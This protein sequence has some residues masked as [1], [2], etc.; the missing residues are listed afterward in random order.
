MRLPKSTQPR[1]A[2]RGLARAR[3]TATGTARP[4]R[5]LRRT[6][7][8]RSRR[9]AP[10]LA[11]A[12]RP[13]V[14]GRPAVALGNA[15]DRSRRLHLLARSDRIAFLQKL[16]EGRA[17]ALRDRILQIPW[18]GR[19]TSRSDALP[20]RREEAGSATARRGLHRLDRVDHRREEDRLHD[21]GGGSL[22]LVPSRGWWTCPLPVPK[23][24]R[25]P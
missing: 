3:R 13:A 20:G 23:C 12:E 6:I 17:H 10:A 18:A 1:L 14:V 19:R 11:M 4:A 7:A 21:F 22:H 2:F 5:A 15:I 16:G 9:T 24:A 8:L 25:K